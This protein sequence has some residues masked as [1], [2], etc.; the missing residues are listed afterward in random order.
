VKDGGIRSTVFCSSGASHVCGRT[1][2][3]KPAHP[4]AADH[5]HTCRENAAT[6]LDEGEDYGA[7]P[8]LWGENHIVSFPHAWGEIP[9]HSEK[10][11]RRLNRQALGSVRTP[12]FSLVALAPPRQ[13]RANETV[14]AKR[15]FSFGFETQLLGMA[16]EKF[17]SS[18]RTSHHLGETSCVCKGEIP[19]LWAAKSVFG[20][21]AS[22]EKYN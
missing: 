8:H 14:S 4:H 12:K 6:N 16:P 9:S 22:V 10:S 3:Q 2:R 13:L 1:R 19:A 7:S 21:K 17:G 20:G 5:P 18:A 15:R 11:S